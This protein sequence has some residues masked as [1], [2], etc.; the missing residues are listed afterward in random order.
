MVSLPFFAPPSMV[1]SMVFC[2]NGNSFINNIQAKNSIIRVYGNIT[3]THS[4]KPMFMLR[5]SGS[6]RYFKAMALGGVPIGVAMPPMLAPIGIA[7]AMPIR[8][9]PSSGNCFN[10]G[11]MNVSIM[12]AVAVLLINI[13]KRPVIKRNPN[14]TNSDFFPNGLKNNLASCTSIPNFDA[15]EAKM[16][17]PKNNIII[18]SEKQAMILAYGMGSP[19]VL[20]GATS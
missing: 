12:A 16:N 2:L 8:P 9:L 11:A 18:G 5:P 1:R 13:E 3:L 14:S 4:P 15:A 7:N 20:P 10:T 6:L 19:K 17:P